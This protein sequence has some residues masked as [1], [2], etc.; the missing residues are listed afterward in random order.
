MLGKVMKETLEEQLGNGNQ[1]HAGRP[2]V[3]PQTSSAPHPLASGPHGC[4]TFQGHP[5]H[6]HQGILATFKP[7]CLLHE[8]V[9][10]PFWYSWVLRT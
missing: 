2:L 10:H 6:L 5:E 7:S 4:G 9:L 8:P 1:A 3:S